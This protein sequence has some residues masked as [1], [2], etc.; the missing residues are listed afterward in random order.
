MAKILYIDSDAE[1]SAM[2]QKKF[3]ASGLECEVALSKTVALQR[4]LEIPFDVILLEISMQDGEG[5]QILQELRTHRVYDVNLKIIIFT[6]ASD[7]E[8]MRRAV[9]LGVNGFISKVDYAPARLADEVNRLLYQF[10][11]Q[12]KNAT[13]FRNGGL[14]V[15]KNKRILFVENEPVFVDMFGKRLRDEG[16]AVD[17][18]TNG[19]DGFDKAIAEKYDLVISDIVMSGLDGRELFHKLKTDDRTRNIPVFLFS[20]SVD[21]CILDELQQQGAKCFQKTHIT[22]SELVREVNDFFK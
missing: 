9:A 21:K 12:E 13:R 8:L 3:V 10:E 22:P 17:V 14:P 16:Y 5:M 7:R 11:E 6:D 2:Y 4:I 20:A 19:S 15:A 18:A 1:L